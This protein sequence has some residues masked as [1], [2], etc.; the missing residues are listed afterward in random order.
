MHSGENSH[1]LGYGIEPVGGTGWGMRVNPSMGLGSSHAIHGVS[2]EPEIAQPA[3][4]GRLSP[5]RGGL[6][7]CLVADT[8]L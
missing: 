5:L 6:T 2:F 3:I 1:G 4:S 8:R 7:R